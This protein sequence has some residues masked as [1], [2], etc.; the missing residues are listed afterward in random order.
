MESKKMKN[1]MSVV[2]PLLFLSYLL[3]SFSEKDDIILLKPCEMATL[4]KFKTKVHSFEK[5]II[6]EWKPK[7]SKEIRLNKK[8]LRS[9]IVDGRTLYDLDDFLEDGFQKEM[10]SIFNTFLE[11]PNILDFTL[12]VGIGSAINGVGKERFLG[13]LHGIK[14]DSI[15]QD[16]LLGETSQC[17]HA[18]GYLTTELDKNIHF[19][20]HQIVFKYQLSNNYSIEGFMTISCETNYSFFDYLKHNG[21]QRLPK[22]SLDSL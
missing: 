1:L 21:S 2:L 11:D 12:G 3:I 5:R 14:E 15:Y 17:K 8:N 10:D 4:E 7:V 9:T 18:I 16:K 13:I 19:K 20:C 6:T 22:V